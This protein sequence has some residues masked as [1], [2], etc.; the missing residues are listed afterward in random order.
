MA[1]QLPADY[2]I[3]HPI[4]TAGSPASKLGLEVSSVLAEV[5]IPVGRAVARSNTALQ[6]AQG[7]LPDITAAQIFG[8]A[9]RDLSKQAD[10]A[11]SIDYVAGDDVAIVQ[12]GLVYVIAEE[13]VIPGDPVFVRFVAGAGGTLLGALRTDADTASAYNWDVAKWASTTAIGEVGKIAI[14]SS[15]GA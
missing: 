12:A 3:D 8:I 15:F 14:A 11:G 13:A 2:A 1:P 5:D 7:I 4:G 9:M 10:A 6:T